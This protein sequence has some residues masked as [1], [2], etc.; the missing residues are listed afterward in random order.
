MKRVLFLILTLCAFSLGVRAQEDVFSDGDTVSIFK[1]MKATEIKST[2]IKYRNPILAGTCSLLMP[3]MGQFYNGQEGK[4]LA[5][6]LGT[7]SCFGISYISILSGIISMTPVYD[8]YN[9]RH[10][11]RN[12]SYGVPLLVASGISFLA[13][14]GLWIYSVVDAYNL[15]DKIN[16]MKGFFKAE[17]GEGKQ[18]S[19]SPNIVYDKDNKLSLGARINFSF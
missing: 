17:L 11:E 4:G 1:R 13:G 16:D 5:F 2:A 15:S 7:Y 14:V 8:D 19:F 9:H 3:G 10:G 6:F 12:V 18:M